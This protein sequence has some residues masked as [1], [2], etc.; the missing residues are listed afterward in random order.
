MEN[1]S[2]LQ[3]LREG[4]SSKQLLNFSVWMAGFNKVPRSHNQRN[5]LLWRLFRFTKERDVN[6]VNQSKTFKQ[7]HTADAR[8][9]KM[10]ASGLG[11]YFWLDEKVGRGFF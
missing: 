8:R 7:I 1:T 10:C 5:K 4:T 11:F 3:L 6:S 2:I 9:G